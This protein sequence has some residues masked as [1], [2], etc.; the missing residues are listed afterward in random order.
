VKFDQ[1]IVSHCKISEFLMKNTKTFFFLLDLK[2][3]HPSNKLWQSCRWQILEG[4]LHFR[5]FDVDRPTVGRL[6]YHG[7][8]GKKIGVWKSSYKGFIF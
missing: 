2:I 7:G 1:V 3:L 8:E 6:N 5:S 4:S